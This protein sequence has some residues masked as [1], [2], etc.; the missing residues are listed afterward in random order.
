MTPQEYDYKLIGYNIKQA[1]KSKR[2]TQ[3]FLA[4]KIGVGDKHVSNLERGK[5]GISVDLL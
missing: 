4:E 1:R 2:Y 3:E 5:A